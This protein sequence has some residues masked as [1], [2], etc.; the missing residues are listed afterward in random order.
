M[1]I[2][3]EA[4]FHE[5]GHAV[6]AYR[7]RFHSIVGTIKLAEYG[8]GQA[9]VSLSKKKLVASGKPANQAAQM[10]K[11]VAADLAV[12]YCAGLVAERIAERMELGLKANPKCA[13]PDHVSALQQLS[14]AGLSQKL[15]LHERAAERLLE[16]DWNLVAALAENLLAS[17]S[18]DAAD[19]LAFLNAQTGVSQ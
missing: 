11:E 3:R 16:K 15:D 17:G 2:K 19:V 13:E 7:S 1:T 6:A 18:A 12:V 8:A 10:D 5:A 4:A 9:D 14:A